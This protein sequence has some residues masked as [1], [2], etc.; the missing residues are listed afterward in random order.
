MLLGPGTRYNDLHI[1]NKETMT[2]KRVH[3]NIT[4]GQ[5][6]DPTGFHTLTCIS[7]STA[8]LFDIVWDNNLERP[9]DNC[10]LLNIDKVQQKADPSLIWT[11]IPISSTFIRKYH[12]TVLEP[13]SRKLWVI[14]GYDGQPDFCKGT[15]EVLHANLI[16]LAPLKDMVIHHAVQNICVNDPRLAKDKLPRNLKHEIEAFR[17]VTP[18]D[19]ICNQRNKCIACH[20]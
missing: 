15:S 9:V 4:S 12:A 1:L 16:K 3:G 7:N 13:V 14:G 6:P 8:I 20:L 10:W 11:K 18:G 17:F 5:V 2:W 19:N